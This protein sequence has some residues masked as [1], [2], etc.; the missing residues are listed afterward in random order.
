MFD[1]LYPA[2]RRQTPD[3]SGS[4]GVVTTTP[5]PGDP[6]MTCPE[7][8]EWFLKPQFDPSQTDFVYSIGDSDQN[9]ANMNPSLRRILARYKGTDAE[10]A[11]RGGIYDP[12]GGAKTFRE[13]DFTQPPVRV[14]R[15][16]ERLDIV[17]ISIDPADSSNTKACEVGI[18]ATGLDLT[19][20]EGFLLEDASGHYTSDE[21][22]NVAHD[23]FER[24]EGRAITIR[25]VIE[26]NRGTKDNSLLKFAE[27][28][29]RRN[30]G[31][32]G[33]AVREIRMVTSK[34][35]KSERAA[36]LP[37]IYKA[38]QMHHL[39]GCEE[40]EKQMKR[41][42]PTNRGKL[43]RADAVV[44]GILDMFGLSDSAHF[45]P[46]LGG[47]A[48]SLAPVGPRPMSSVAVGQMPST[49]PRMTSAAPFQSA[50]GPWSAGR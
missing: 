31:Q 34:K 15:A 44:Q 27:M 5:P 37:G 22:P 35:A 36:P 25:F 29:R 40:A 30:R 23:V 1:A 2:F 46:T 24:W 20:G 16:P 17:T 39:P 50:P 19:A 21:W 42:D 7:L 47:A 11:E 26:D 3:G 41:L 28:L 8:A 9:F 18:A 6:P 14:W 45:A 10:A 49:G 38:G 33:I 13:I 48:S 32:A 12:Q 4:R 43:D